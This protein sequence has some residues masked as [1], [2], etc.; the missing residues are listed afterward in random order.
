MPVEG[1]GVSG[2]EHPFLFFF[3]FLRL[4]FWWC[5]CTMYLL[6]CQVRVTVGDSGLCCV[7]GASFER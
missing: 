2:R 3:S 4:Y 5:S 1:G 7:C 6:V